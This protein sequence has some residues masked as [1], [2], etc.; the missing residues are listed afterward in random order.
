MTRLLE[1]IQKPCREQFSY[2]VAMRAELTNSGGALKCCGF[3]SAQGYKG[4]TWNYCCHDSWS[5][6]LLLSF[7]KESILLPFW[8]TGDDCNPIPLY[9]RKWK[10]KTIMFKQP[11]WAYLSSLKAHL[12]SHTSYTSDKVGHQSS[13]E[14]STSHNVSFSLK[15]S[16]CSFKHRPSL[17]LCM[18][19]LK[20]LHFQ[21]KTR[22]SSEP[23]LPQV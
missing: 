14:D 23:S 11:F 5:E 2:S 3:A 7:L 16:Y 10:C 8:A 21:F 13:H 6:T 22:K 17:T 1:I 19:G 20:T 12:W 4:P 15:M 18:V 9:L